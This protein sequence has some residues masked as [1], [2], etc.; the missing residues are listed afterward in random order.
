MKNAVAIMFFALL[1]MAAL[2]LKYTGYAPHWIVN[3]VFFL[4]GIYVYFESFNTYRRLRLI[5]DTATSKI[6]SLSV[7][8]VEVYGKAKRFPG[9]FDIYHYLS[10]RELSEFPMSI[11]MKFSGVLFDA[12]SFGMRGGN[13]RVF[14]FYIEDETG[15]VLVDPAEAEVIVDTKVWRNGDVFYRESE[16]KEGDYVYCIGTAYRKKDVDI[17]SEINKA[18]KEAKKSKYTL[19]RFDT[20]GDGKISPDEWAVARKAIENE[21]IDNNLA[22]GKP[23]IPSIVKG[24]ED[25]ILIISSKK[26]GILVR[27]YYVKSL[28]FLLAGIAITIYSFIV[29]FRY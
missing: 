10:A 5:R 9:F 24:K 2:L 8:L 14:P 11:F 18:I 13:L 7:G 17:A 25:S 23:Y 4:C 21:V 29:T 22:A 15:A 3:A 28:L 19:Q 6:G 12:S 1:F 26:E 20:D 16:I 27:K